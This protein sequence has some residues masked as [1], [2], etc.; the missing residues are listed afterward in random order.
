MCTNIDLWKKGCLD[1]YK[2]SCQDKSVYQVRSALIF[3]FTAGLFYNQK[4]ISVVC[5][6][7]TH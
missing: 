1:K 6:A 2:D 5:C 7:G 3:V 4:L